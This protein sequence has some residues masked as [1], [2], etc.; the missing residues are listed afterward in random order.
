[1]PEHPAPDGGEAPRPGSRYPVD[2]AAVAQA[3]VALGQLKVGIFIVAFEAERFIA[4]VLD[5][6]PEPLR[7]LFTEVL[8]IDDSSPDHTFEAARRAAEQMGFRNV[9]VLRTPFNRGYGGNQKLGYLHAIKRGFDYVVLLHGDGQY[10]PEYL[11]QIVNALAAGR[12]DAL[13]ASR[14]INPR[15]ALRGGMPLYK[16]VGNQVL[17]AIENRVLGTHLSEFHSGYRAYRVEALRSIPFQ[18]NSDDFHFDT[19]ILIQLLS[20]GRVVSEIP[21]PTFYGDEI[22]HVNGLRYAG[23]CLKAVTKARLGRAGVFYEPKFDFGA[24]D[25]SGYRV[26]Q[27]DNSLHQHVLARPW[28]P[29]W[30]VADLGASRGVLSAQLARKVEHVT[31][32]DVV[33]PPEAGGAEAIALDLDTDFVAALGPDRYD[34][35][36]ALDVIEHLKRPEEG[37]RR[38]AEILEPRGVLYASTGNIAFHV[39]RLSLFLGQFNYGKRGILDLTHTRLFTVA[40]FKQLLVDG[41][42]VIREVHGFGPPIRDMVGGSAGLRAADAASGR[43]ARLYP[44]LFAFSFLVVAEKADELEDIYAR[45]LAAP[46]SAP[47]RRRRGR[48]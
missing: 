33:R 19:E 34:C 27:A 10:A 47:P 7:D 8:V 21:V 45:T 43:L 48:A 46:E 44:R 22:S 20:T 36:L 15:D 17:T 31:A 32:A 1:M 18:L 13:I 14:M 24:F 30:R 23:N 38:I 5:R 12:P 29:G 39:M 37:V 25:D 9:T 11:P 16:W 2:E 41:G 35:V 28:P 6:I 3:A 40:S 4:S 26:K 42:F